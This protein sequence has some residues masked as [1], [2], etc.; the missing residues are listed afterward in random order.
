[1]PVIFF[2]FPVLFLFSS[3]IQSK[4]SLVGYDFRF[5]WPQITAVV[6]ISVSIILLGDEEKEGE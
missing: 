2:F 1:M 4:P 3:V 5:N 6:L